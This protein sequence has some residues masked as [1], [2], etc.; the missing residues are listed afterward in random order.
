M[1][2]SVVS[3]LGQEVFDSSGSTQGTEIRDAASQSPASCSI[4]GAKPVETT[5]Q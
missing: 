3:A 1:L 5:V 4:S 2:G